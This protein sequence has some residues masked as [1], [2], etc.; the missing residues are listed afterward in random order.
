M[1]YE[2]ILVMELYNL[3]SVPVLR[4]SADESYDDIQCEIQAAIKKIKDTDDK[5][6]KSFNEKERVKKT[7][8][9][10]EKYECN[11][12]TRGTFPKRVLFKIVRKSL[13]ICSTLCALVYRIKHSTF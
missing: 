1:P 8:D 13:P 7:Y 5:S 10:L 4:Y 12:L 11:L 3:F 2:E 6:C 9:F